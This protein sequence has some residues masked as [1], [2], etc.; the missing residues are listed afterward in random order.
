MTFVLGRISVGSSPAPTSVP[1]VTTPSPMA[2]DGGA[3]QQTVRDQLV[4]C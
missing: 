1:A 2:T 4:A 3:C